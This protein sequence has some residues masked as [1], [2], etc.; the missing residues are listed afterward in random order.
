MSGVSAERL[1][2]RAIETVTSSLELDAV[3]SATVDLVMEATAGDACLLL[4][5]DADQ[6]CLVLRAASS[7]FQD[8]VGKVRLRLGEGV[9]G[10]VAAHREVAVIP[11]DKWADPR[12]KYFPE[13][14][15]EMFKA[16]LSVPVVSR[17]GTLVG[18]FNVHSR[19]RREFSGADMDF[20]RLTASLVAGAIEHA[21]L[22]RAIADKEAA[23]ET[24]VRKTIEAQE[25]ERRRVAAEIH[26]GVT[27]QLVSVWYRLQA[28]GRSLRADPDRAEQDLAAARDLVDEALAEART[29]I[30]DLRPSV[31]DDLGLSPSLR[32]LAMRQLED[33]VDL[34]L[35]IDNVDFLPAHREVALYRIA[36]E[37]ITNVRKHAGASRVTTSTSSSRTTAGDSIRRNLGRHHPRPH[38]A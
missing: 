29:A 7:A 4:L 25:E 6:D 31:L 13:L 18:V 15:G 37:A 17:S 38:S 24:L 35:A 1:L 12:W 2:H 20:L 5:W 10:W 26:D 34:E 16:M 14:H 33:E 9:S 3:L 30:Y 23:L 32:T 28:I 27:Q 11:E 8:A 22:F 21:N 36:Q 19:E